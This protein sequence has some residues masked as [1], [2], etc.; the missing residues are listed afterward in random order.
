ML[1][2][3]SLSHSVSKPAYEHISDRSD[4]FVSL[5]ENTALFLR[6]GQIN[7]TY[8][9]ALTHGAVANTETGRVNHPLTPYMHWLHL[10]SPRSGVQMV[11]FGTLM[12]L[13]SGPPTYIASQRHRK[14]PNPRDV[15]LCWSCNF[16]HAGLPYNAR[17]RCAHSYTPGRPIVCELPPRIIVSPALLSF[18]KITWGTCDDFGVDST[19]PNLQCGYLDV[20]LD[21]HDS[22]VGNARLAVARYIATA[23]MKLGTI[24]F[25]PGD[26]IDPPFAIFPL[27]PNFYRRTWRFGNRGR[28]RTWRVR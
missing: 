19:D 20:P 14:H 17:G 7:I 15:P 13:A 1:P 18:L 22:S 10:R 2:L 26:P 16:P 27:I 4:I 23:P 6:P 3:P 9:T 5:L 21:Y 11:W 28:F 24:F 8:Y 25:N 12:F